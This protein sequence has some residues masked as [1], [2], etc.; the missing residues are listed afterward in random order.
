MPCR[1]YLIKH[2]LTEDCCLNRHYESILFRKKL[3]Y[4]WIDVFNRWHEIS[5]DD[6]G[7]RCCDRCEIGHR[8]RRRENID[9]K[10]KQKKDDREKRAGTDVEK[11]D[12]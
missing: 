3:L 5:L 7:V 12:K 8:R 10:Q 4:T 1:K 6:I 9:M 11:M 2:L